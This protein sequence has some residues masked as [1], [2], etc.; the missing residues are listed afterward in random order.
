M[1][2]HC[3]LYAGIEKDR[4]PVSSARRRH[5]T[6]SRTLRAVK[7]GLREPL[8]GHVE[9][10][11]GTDSPTNVTPKSFPISRAHALTNKKTTRI[12]SCFMSQVSTEQVSSRQ[13]RGGGN[14]RSS[15]VDL[16][17][18]GR[19]RPGNDWI[20]QHPTPMIDN[21][22]QLTYIDAVGLQPLRQRE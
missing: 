3:A 14:L 11:A 12:A 4:V 18:L 8:H 21:P 17:K 2:E 5:A 7:A 15:C 16:R 22:G 6:V 1:P 9:W 10:H 19:D 20:F 13:S